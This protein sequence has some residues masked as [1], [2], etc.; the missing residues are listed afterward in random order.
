V[1]RTHGLFALAEQ[2]DQGA[3]SRDV[4]PRRRVGIMV[5]WP[6][7]GSREP[8]PHIAIDWLR[9][10]RVTTQYVVPGIL[11]FAFLVEISGTPTVFAYDYAIALVFSLLTLVLNGACG[12]VVFLWDIDRLFFSLERKIDT[13]TK[14][15]TAEADGSLLGRV[16]DILASKVQHLRAEAVRA[17]ERAYWEDINAGGVLAFPQPNIARAVEHIDEGRRDLLSPLAELVARTVPVG[18]T[19]AALVSRVLFKYLAPE[20][21]LR[22][23]RRLILR[24]L[25]QLSALFVLAALCFYF[26][27]LGWSRV[28]PSVF[29]NQAVSATSVFYVQLDLMLRGALFDFMEHTHRSISPI[30]I[31]QRA[32]AFV[33]YT[34]SFR[35]FVVAYVIS[36]LFRVARF[37]VRRWRV[38][39]R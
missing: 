39:L 9:L 28:S 5:E 1:R 7:G 14:T 35:M 17:I 30:A 21:K 36:S 34:L 37:V 24:F 2:L 6:K 4:E 38:L 13:Q 23:Y 3:R 33:Y 12:W 10:A 11:A 22:L 29:A 16:R 8:M 26:S 18:N 25:S 32:T 15:S 27:I 31:N 20:V 19:P